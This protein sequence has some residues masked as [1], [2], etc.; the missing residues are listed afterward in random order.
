M[1]RHGYAYYNYLL[2][3][4]QRNCHVK[5]YYIAVSSVLGIVEVMSFLLF[6][7]FMPLKLDLKNNGAVIVDNTK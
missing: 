5:D 2:T 4:L 1:Q 6:L 7:S 3:E